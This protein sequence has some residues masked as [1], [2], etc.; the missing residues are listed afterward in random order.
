MQRR[1]F[2]KSTGAATL[3]LGSATLTAARSAMAHDDASARAPAIARGLRR[4]RLASA[5]GSALGGPGD[6]LHRFARRVAAATGGAI[7]IEIDD[8]VATTQ[9]VFTAVMTG[10]A[11]FYCGDDGDLVGLHP[12]FAFVSG[13]PGDSGLSAAHLDAWLTAGGGQELWDDLAAEFNMKGS[14][15]AHT[16]RSFGLASRAPV[17]T[18]ADLRGRR[19]AAPGLAAELVRAVDGVPVRSISGASR[20]LAAEGDIDAAELLGIE[21][22][23]PA[24][25]DDEGK[26]AALHL[27][28]PGLQPSGCT[29]TLGMRRSFWDGLPNSERVLLTALAA[30][31]FAESRAEAAAATRMVERAGL[32]SSYRLTTSPAVTRQLARHAATIVAHASGFDALAMRINASYMAFKGREA[33]GFVA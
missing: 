8:T 7:T 15:V 26:R 2:L 25:A 29:L 1:D 27:L 30:Q 24:P 13:L 17:T 19:I 9:R 4:L 5:L 12:G 18:I 6:H 10:N 33:T 3:A 20:K 11:D 21:A 31:S 22:L 16:G 23:Y 14:A 28:A 32:L